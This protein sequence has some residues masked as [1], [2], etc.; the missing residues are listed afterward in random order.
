MGA[1]FDVLTQDE[2]VQ[3]VVAAAANGSGF[4]LITANLDHARQYQVDDRVR[5]YFD[6]ADS[7][8]ADGAPIV[9]ASRVA[10]T[11]LPE[12][13]AGSDM[14][15]K[16]CRA[17]AAAGISVYLLGAD[18]GIAEQAAQMLVD[19][20]ADLQIAGWHC[21]ARGFLESPTALAALE[22]DVREAR[23]DLVLVALGFPLQD[24]VIIRLRRSLPGAGFVGVGISLSF[25]T[26]H[27][28]RAPA[29][30]QRSGLE[31]VHRLVQE[32]QRLAE[33]YL[34]RGIPFAALL[35]ARAAWFRTSGK[36]AESWGASRGQAV[37]SQMM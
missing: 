24:E 2:T 12:R 20:I 7:V 15:P 37:P 18:P 19:D 5:E 9:W 4:H 1:E 22:R 25:L 26:G 30:M 13:V 16:L 31:W 21:P 11:P 14:V 32:P 17:A 34:R 35:L 27:V 33:R 23:P 28:T 3:R 8:V 36:T 10:G 29:W 6:I